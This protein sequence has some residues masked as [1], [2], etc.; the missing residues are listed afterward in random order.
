M[1]QNKETRW[2]F[3]DD[4]WDGFTEPKEKITDERMN[5]IFDQIENFY[6]Y[7]KVN[8]RIKFVL[9]HPYYRKQVHLKCEQLDGDGRILSHK[10][11]PDGK[12]AMHED[13]N[14]IKHNECQKCTPKNLIVY[15][16]DYYSDG[17]FYDT[18]FYCKHCETEDLNKRVLYLD[19]CGSDDEDGFKTVRG[20]NTIIIRKKALHA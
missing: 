5:E 15:H 9:H 16:D 3:H 6:K 11:I 19:N 1:N 8:A 13:S 4:P 10:S 18:Y 20:H 7:A 12:V 14:L 2:I 17:R